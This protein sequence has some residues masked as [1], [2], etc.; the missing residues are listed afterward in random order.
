VRAVEL[1]GTGKKVKVQRYFD[2]AVTTRGG[3]PD[4]EELRDALAEI[5]KSLPK[6]SVIG[7]VD[8]H[9]T[10]T[11]EIPVPFKSDDQIR[12]VIKYEAEHHLHDCD[13]DDVIVQYAKVGESKE[14]TNLLVF[15]AKKDDVSR[16]IESCRD[17]GVELLA[18]DLDANGLLSAAQFA[19]L[20]DD[21]PDCILLNISNRST[22]MLFV[23]EGE[24]R[25]IRSVRMGM[26][27]ISQGLARDMDIELSEADK[28]LADIATSPEAG[29]LI[30][31]ADGGLDDKADTEKSHSELEHDLFRQKRDE[32][33]ARLKREFVRSSAALRG[34]AAGRV[35]VAGPGLRVPGLLDLLS[36]KLGRELETLRVSDHFQGKI[37]GDVEEFDANA[38]VACGLA[39]KGLGAAPVNLDFRQE[40]LQVA[41][42]FELLKGALAVCVTLLFIA[43][44]GAS[45]FYV[46]K[47]KDL[48]G[49]DMYYRITTDAYKQ[50][51]GIA[52]AYNGLGDTLVPPR[53]RVDPSEVERGDT[54]TPYLALKRFL[55]ELRRMERHLEK[56]VG[57]QGLDPIKSALGRWNSIMGALRGIHKK[58]EYIDIEGMRIEQGIVGM[59]LI[60]TDASNASKVQKQISALPA[61][62]DLEADPSL[63]FGPLRDS[64]Y[65]KVRLEWREKKNSRGRRR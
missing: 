43:L 6:N 58:I 12:K 59:N 44:M 53:M 2:R 21:S 23:H 41:N 17:A 24:L 48:Q 13:A 9:D 1:N 25:A 36:E 57:G 30:I 3:Q 15:A 34:A 28:K 38:A 8:A 14:G 39:L 10:I 26:D 29:D 7:C 22:E 4:P 64:D 52:Q 31:P 35:I 19:G 56:K 63:S 47:K 20:L 62:E 55:K 49:E 37:N 42:K 32:F 50:F 65:G 5:F 45:F 54:D 18:L 11:R 33:V 46:K 16:R 51:N 60:V 61:M 40:E 27:S